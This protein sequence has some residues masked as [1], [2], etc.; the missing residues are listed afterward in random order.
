MISALFRDITLRTYLLT[1]WCRVLLKKLA[2][3][4]LVKKFPAFYGTRRFITTFTSFR[5]PSLFCAMLPLE[6]LPHGDPSA[7]VVY[8]AYS[9]NSFF[10][11]LDFLTVL[12]GTDRLS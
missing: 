11:F 4:Q 12:D 7:G 9:D 2:G 1:P 5:H 6:T 3:L 8:A 10:N